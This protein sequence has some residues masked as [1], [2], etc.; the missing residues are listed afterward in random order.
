[1][2][3]NMSTRMGFEPTFWDANGLAVNHSATLSLAFL[4]ILQTV[5]GCFHT[6]SS[7]RAQTMLGRVAAPCG[8]ADNKVPQ[9]HTTQSENLNYTF[10]YVCRSFKEKVTTPC[11]IWYL[12]RTFLNVTQKENRCG[13]IWIL[14]YSFIPCDYLNTRYYKFYF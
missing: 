7:L 10:S 5:L 1:M 14:K 8:G 4:T 6:F 11:P 12:P 3:K 2:L 13:K 9:L